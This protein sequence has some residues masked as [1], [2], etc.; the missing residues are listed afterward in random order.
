MKLWATSRTRNEGC[1]GCFVADE[2]RSGRRSSSR[3]MGAAAGAVGVAGLPW[4]HAARRRAPAHGRPLP[5]QRHVLVQGGRGGLRRRTIL[6]TSRYAT[7]PYLSF[8]ALFLFSVNFW[9]FQLTPQK[10]GSPS[11]STGRHTK[12]FYFLTS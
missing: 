4:R 5:L 12:I 2:R 10:S 3:G 7:H 9:G 1:M 11:A 8:Y 6:P